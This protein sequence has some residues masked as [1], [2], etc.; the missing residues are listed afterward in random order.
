M[1]FR[2]ITPSPPLQEFVRD[3][4]IAHFIFDKNQDIPFKPYSPKPEQTI[5][6]LPKGN[7][8]VLNPMNG[9][10]AVSPVISICGQQLSRYN[11]YL[12]PEYQML[13]VHF[14]PGALFRLLRI[15][16]S[17]FT[18]C[19]LDATSII[20]H[21]L[22]EVNERLA[23]CLNY[24]QMIA[25]IEHYLLNKINKVTTETHP[26]DKVAACLFTN[27]SRFS[28]D[29]LA[30]QS[31]LCP[32]Q[33]NRKFTQ[34]MGVGPKLYSRIVRFYKAYQYRETHPQ[35]DWLTIALLFGYVDYQHMVKDFKDFA[36]VTPNLWIKQ[37]N[38]S[39]ERILQLE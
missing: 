35:E 15:P 4:L 31:C 2:Y 9:H 18:D 25:V 5:T 14:Q 20:S 33:F 28:L 24:V 27:P 8:T 12:T 21:E 1:I 7:L 3:Y 6:F 34:R 22:L 23:N 16:L 36:N 29:W 26:L 10:T 38:Q 17:E 13:R 30:N 19:W 11:F 32:R 37:D 39:P